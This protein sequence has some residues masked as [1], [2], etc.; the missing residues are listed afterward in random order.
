MLVRR[1]QSTN[2]IARFTLILLIGLTACKQKPADQNI[3]SDT[4]PYVLKDILVSKPSEGLMYFKGHLFTGYA[5]T[6]HNHD[7]FNSKT[8][9][10]NGK[11]DGKD[12]K[13]FD[14]GSLSY[15]ANY[16]NG[17]LHGKVTSWWR[18]GHKRSESNYV[19]GMAQGVQMQWYKSGLKFK[20]ITLVDGK[21]EGIQQSW[22][23][24]GKIYNNYE[25]K[26]GRIFG[27]KRSK[28]CY[29][30]DDEIIQIKSD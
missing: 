14:D 26:D 2:F 13:W 6:F 9:Y 29:E 12:Q 17:H 5:V 30:L 18:N 4:P 25:A 22:R 20:K 11:K 19:N 7:F 1:V 24:N 15:E 27:L 21:E 8:S 10:I 16:I 23:E 3:A 28:L